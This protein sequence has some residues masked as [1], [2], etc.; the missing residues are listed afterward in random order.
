MTITSL[1]LLWFNS[2][3]LFRSI[4]LG[5]CGEDTVKHCFAVILFGATVER[6]FAVYLTL[7]D[8]ADDTDFRLFVRRLLRLTW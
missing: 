4:S 8:R 2:G 1:T 3:A 5:V 6:C 7:S